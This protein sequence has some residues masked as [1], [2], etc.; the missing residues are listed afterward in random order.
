M[1]PPAE[2][3]EN[4]STPCSY[5]KGSQAPSLARI[6]ASGP[7]PVAGFA[8]YLDFHRPRLGVGGRHAEADFDA[9]ARYPVWP[10][11]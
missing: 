8:D 6:T 5:T 3:S 11:A 7:G 4:H 10:A 1:P 9:A 2:S